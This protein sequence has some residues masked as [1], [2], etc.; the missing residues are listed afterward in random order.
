MTGAHQFA[1]EVLVGPNPEATLD[2]LCRVASCVNPSHLDPASHRTNVLRGV[3]ITSVNAKLMKCR[4]GHPLTGVNL[5]FYEA[6]KKRH[7]RT[8][9]RLR[10]LGVAV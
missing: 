2:H 6:Q 3:G 5:Y 9:R 1:F 7:C 8:C 10:R 4:R